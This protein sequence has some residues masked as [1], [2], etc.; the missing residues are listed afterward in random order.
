MGI[1]KIISD[2]IKW[3]IYVILK[4]T[5]VSCIVTF[6]L[7]NINAIDKNALA[8]G[9]FFKVMALLM[10]SDLF[11]KLIL[12]FFLFL[13]YY[14]I[15]P[16]FSIVKKKDITDIQK[17]NNNNNNT[18]VLNQLQILKNILDDKITYIWF[19]DN[20]NNLL[21]N[22]D[23]GSNNNDNNYSIATISY[24]K[25]DSILIESNSFKQ[26][27]IDLEFTIPKDY[28]A[29]IQTHEFMLNDGLFVTRSVL[30]CGSYSCLDIYIRNYGT[31]PYE[32]KKDIPLCDIFFIKQTGI[33]I[34]K[35]TKRNTNNN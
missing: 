17:S 27:I 21:V 14:M 28:I 12:N 2:T 9:F 19:R 18:E 23:D 11:E 31:K 35:T 26:V 25:K 4:C 16:L 22:Y 10:F 5:L 15:S 24:D 20:N 30:T 34:Q 7:L 32:I 3:A 1:I 8:H 6:V 13:D 29:M 33:K